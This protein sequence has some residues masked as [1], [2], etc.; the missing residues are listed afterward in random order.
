MYIY[1][2]IYLL[3]DNFWSYSEHDFLNG[4]IL[5]RTQKMDEGLYRAIGGLLG[6]SYKPR[7]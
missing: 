4:R 2:Y 6:W 1:I 3:L 5:W 7:C